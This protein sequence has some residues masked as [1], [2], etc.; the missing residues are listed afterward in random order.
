MVHREAIFG[1][2]INIE[3]GDY[4]DIG[5]NAVIPG[6]TVIGKNVLMAP[7]YSVFSVNHRFDDISR[8]IKS[9]GVTEKTDYY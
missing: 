8:T 5:V 6:D 9:Q 4:S 2:G 1:I 7:N 3:I